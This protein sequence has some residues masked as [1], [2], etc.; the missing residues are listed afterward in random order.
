MR[1]DGDRSSRPPTEVDAA[2]RRAVRAV[3]ENRVKKP[4]VEPAKRR[5]ESEEAQNRRR[6]EAQRGNRAR[7]PLLIGDDDE[8]GLRG[9]RKKKG[10]KVA[11]NKH[12]FVRPTAP[13]VREVR[14]PETISVAD[15]AEAMSVKATEVIKVMFKMGTMVTINQILDQ[16]TAAIVVEEMGHTYKLLNDND[17]EEAITGEVAEG[18]SVGTT[19]APVVTIMGHVDHGKTS[20]L[21][22]IRR[23]KVAAGEAGGI[24]QHI[25]A[26]HVTT[27]KG[28]ITF[29][30]TPGHAAFTSMRARGAKVTDLVVLVVAADDGV[31]PQ[32]EEAVQH[33]RAANVPLVV[34]VNKVDKPEADL[35]RIRTDLTS[36]HV[37]PEEFGGDTQFVNVSAKTGQGIDALLDAILIQS[38]VLELTAHKDGPARG[39]VIESRLDKGRG[40]V[41]TVLVQ[42]GCLRRGDYVLCGLEHGRVRAM[43]NEVGDSIDEAGP[44]IPVEILGLSGTPNAGDEMVVVAD[45]RKAREVALFRQGKFRE[46]KIARET[47]GKLENVFQQL[48]EGKLHTLNI[49]LKTD[50]QGSAEALADAL[51]K[52]STAEVKVKIVLSGVG[53]ITESDAQLAVTSDAIVIGFNVR[54]DGT[55]RKILEEQSIQLRYYSIIYEA[56]D[57]VKAAMQ[58]MLAPTFREQITGVAQVRQVFRSSKFGTIAGCMVVEGIIKRHNPIRVLREDVVIYQGELESLKRFKDDA[59]EVRQGFECGIGVRGYSDVREGDKIEVFERIQVERTL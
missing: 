37:V 35:L 2:N 8:G 38:E 1:A 42:D 11:A 27:D 58:G 53:G 12:G 26:Y 30:D 15:L 47:K 48:E 24:T 34:A 44:S 43:L 25:G 4:L 52:L 49:V 3:P 45:E 50:V 39:A 20:L 41:A 7:E 36:L 28:M 10:G 31:M 55:A 17:L 13:V 57:D 5:T 29:L 21:D 40:P 56:L 14:L 6:L 32:T 33:S 16:E 51:V 9:G 19:R 46:V 23:T 22:Y 59:N 18:R 54:A